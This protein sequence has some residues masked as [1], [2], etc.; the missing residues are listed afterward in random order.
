MNLFTELKRRNVFRV[1]VFYILAAW[2]VVQ[3]AETLLPVFDVPD[4]A[5]RIIVLILALGFPLAIVFSW[6]FEL[7]PEGLKRDKDAR[8]GPEIKQ[9]TARKL[10]WA[11][12][13]AAVLAIGLLTTDRLMPERV[14]EATASG[15][16]THE[17]ASTAGANPATESYATSIA[18]LPFV[19]MS[20]D[21]Q[22]AYFADGISEELLNVLVRV[23]KLGVASRTSS[24]AYKGRGMPATEIASELRVNHILEGSVRKA[25]NRVRITAQ[26]I[27]ALNDRHLWSETYDRELTDIFAIQ[28]EIA[29]AIVDALRGTL[30]SD[31][32]LNAVEVLADTDDI[33]A[34]ELYLQAREMFRD[35]TDLP[36][37][38]RLFERAVELD[39]E[40]AR[41]WEGMA[42][43]GAVIEDW[44]FVD[45]P[46]SEMAATA[47][48]RALAL[49]PTLSMP[50]SVQSILENQNRPIDFTEALRLADRG[51]E[52]DPNNATARLWRSIH[53]MNLGFFDR[54]LADQDRCLDIDPVY[55]NCRRFK[56]LSL[57]FMGK[58]DDALA[59]FLTGVENGFVR[60]RGLSFIRPL[61]DR[62]QPAMAVM[63]MMIDQKSPKWQQA[64]FEFHR[65]GRA[66]ANVREVVEGSGDLSKYHAMNYLT[67]GAYDLAADVPEMSESTLVYW[68]PSLPG[69]RNSDAFKRILDRFGVP[70]HW[71]VNGFPPQCRPL[72]VDDFECD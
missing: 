64:M 72:G 27:D 22:N 49:D 37:A 44:G 36:E 58:P 60:N 5:I 16:T 65:T 70:A 30:G 6:V 9:Q 31:E 2:V 7:T 33:G 68:D 59:V 50:W 29:N 53:W 35:R 19:N 23:D 25:G 1:A 14:L 20:G 45:R 69:L 67:L 34:Y 11:T 40:F 3:V 54:A 51:I 52:A 71:R 28:D 26:L 13:I 4:T 63:L 62:G 55:E 47:A 21:A 61:L 17:S 10:N 56:A 48:D 38:F 15:S 24:F 43:V 8:V 39:P 18:V 46:Y 57:Q 32:E 41:A 42:A 12:L 66:P